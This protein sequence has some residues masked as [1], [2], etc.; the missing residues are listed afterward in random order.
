MCGTRA[1]QPAIQLHLPGHTQPHLMLAGQHHAGGSRSE[2][3]CP[4]CGPSSCRRCC[5]A[6][7]GSCTPIPAGPRRVRAGPWRRSTA[8]TPRRPPPP[9][10]SRPTRPRSAT[11][12]RSRVRPGRL[13]RCG[14]WA[15]SRQSPLSFSSSVRYIDRDVPWNPAAGAQPQH[16]GHR[17]KLDEPPRHDQGHQRK[18]RVRGRSRGARTVSPLLSVSRPQCD[19]GK[20]N[21]VTHGSAVDRRAADFVY[22]W[23]APSSGAPDVV[24]FQATLVKTEYVFWTSIKSPMLKLDPTVVVID[25]TGTGEPLSCSVFVMVAAACLGVVWHV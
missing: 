3:R 17:G 9:T 23:Q 7:A 15:C 5:A 24:Q 2:W 25:T 18:Y 10:S 16:V 13:S 20:A 6:S 1:G 19:S 8:P 11:G 14:P 12:R 4:A 21:A 22:T